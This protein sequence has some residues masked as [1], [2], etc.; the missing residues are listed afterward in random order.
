MATENLVRVVL[1]GFTG[2]NA[3]P[4]AVAGLTAGSFD[5]AGSFWS[6]NASTLVL[7]VADSAATADAIAPGGAVVVAASAANGTTTPH[8]G[9]S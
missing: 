4:L 1:D 2:A 6:V 5:A 7:A 9:C 8:V 3:S